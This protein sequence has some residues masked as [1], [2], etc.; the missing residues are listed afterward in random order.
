MYRHLEALSEATVTGFL[1]QLT[2]YLPKGA[3]FPKKPHRV[4]GVFSHAER[5]LAVR[6]EETV[7]ETDE[8][9]KHVSIY[10]RGI[11]IENNVPFSAAAERIVSVAERLVVDE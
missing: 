10:G 2:S 4:G 7:T 1:R 11:E 8:R 9:L 5:C 6:L 3:P